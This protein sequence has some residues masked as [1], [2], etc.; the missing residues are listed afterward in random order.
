MNAAE[1]KKRTPLHYTALKGD[2]IGE[3][4]IENGANVMLWRKQRT[5]LHL[6]EMKSTR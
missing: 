1:K 3:V 4:L 2:E 6:A 5:A